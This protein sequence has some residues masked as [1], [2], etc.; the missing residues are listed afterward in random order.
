MKLRELI[1]IINFRF[2]NEDGLTEDDKYDSSL[3]RLIIDRHCW[4]YVGADD[5]GCGGAIES[6]KEFVKSDI[7]DM[8]V[9]SIS[10][11]EGLHCIDIM[12]TIY[13]EEDV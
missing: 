4:I 12:L 3:I 5:Y 1:P 9:N 8:E 6:I 10:M 7:L 13:K 11:N 2:Y